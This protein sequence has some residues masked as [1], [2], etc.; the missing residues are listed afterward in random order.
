MKYPSVSCRVRQRRRCQ[1]SRD[2]LFFFDQDKVK[3]DAC[4]SLPITITIQ[5]LVRFSEMFL[6]YQ[7]TA[8]RYYRT[9]FFNRVAVPKAPPLTTTAHHGP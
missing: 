8:S 6:V 5:L 1:G 2:D 9:F 7:R 4:L 3:L